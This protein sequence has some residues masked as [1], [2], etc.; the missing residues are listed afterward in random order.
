MTSDP[1]AALAAVGRELADAVAAATAP[2]VVRCVADVLGAWEAADPSAVPAVPREELLRRAADTG[3]RAEQQVGAALRGMLAG[4]VDAQSTTPLAVVRGAVR[5]PT[6]LLRDAGVPAV[7][8]DRFAEERFPDDDYDLVP[9][10]LAKLDP[11]LT[12][13]AIAWGAAKAMAHRRRHRARQP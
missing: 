1:D 7:R 5:Y 11:S 9:A 3:R 4:D 13:I 10:S 12:E 2:W 6:A 8:R